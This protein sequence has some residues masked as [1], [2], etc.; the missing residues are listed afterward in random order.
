MAYNEKT[1]KTA[2]D[3][4]SKGSTDSI[5]KEKPSADR[6]SKGASPK[7]STGP[8]SKRNSRRSSPARAPK[9]KDK[10]WDKKGAIEGPASGADRDAAA[11]ENV[12]DR[13]SSAVAEGLDYP[14]SR[15]DEM[16]KKKPRG[17]R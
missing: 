2:A 13:D 14:V 4:K 15:A 3:S 6:Q 10:Q 1:R 8:T 11:E 9:R 17:R 12:G 16:G 7:F 5:S